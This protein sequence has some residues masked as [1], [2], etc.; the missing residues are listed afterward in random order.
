MRNCLRPELILIA[1]QP[2][3][4]AFANTNTHDLKPN[5]VFG[6]YDFFHYILIEDHQR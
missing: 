2:E 6:K 3:F 4:V 1:F 5:N